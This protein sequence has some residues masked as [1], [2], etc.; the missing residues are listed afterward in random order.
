MHHRQPWHACQVA[1]ER[2]DGEVMF[3]RGSR[4]K[5]INVAYQANGTPHTS[6]EIGVPFEDGVCQLIWGDFPKRLA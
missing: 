4:N 5:R 2:D 6:A 1:I 3:E